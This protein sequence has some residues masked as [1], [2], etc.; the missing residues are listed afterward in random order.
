M[1]A[2]FLPIFLSSFLP[3]FKC[4]KAVLASVLFLKFQDIRFGSTRLPFLKIPYVIFFTSLVFVELYV[5]SLAVTAHL[6][7]QHPRV[8]DLCATKETE[9]ESY[10]LPPIS[11]RIT[12]LHRVRADAS[13][14]PPNIEHVTE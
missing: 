7:H 14:L 9:H 2:N 11:A 10:L 4:L 5:F 6:N 13:L 3:I 12:Y 8:Q 1:G